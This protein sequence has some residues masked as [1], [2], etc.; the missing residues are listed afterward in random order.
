MADSPLSQATAL[1]V[2]GTIV[3]VTDF[4]TDYSLIGQYLPEVFVFEAER[5]VAGVYA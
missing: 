5:L 3:P 1:T 2:S 4:D